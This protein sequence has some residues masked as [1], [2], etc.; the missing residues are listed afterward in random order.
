MKYADIILPIPLEQVYTYGVPLALQEKINI[1]CRVE[2]SFGKRKIYSGI[3]KKL[4]DHKPEVYEVKPIRTII[5][6]EPIVTEQ[7][8]QLWE[9]MAQYYMCTLGEVMNAAMPTHYKLVSDT[10]IELQPDADID[11]Q[12]LSDDEFMIME[13]LLINQSRNTNKNK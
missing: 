10:I 3:V 7:Q 4:H 8:L 5:D 13:A 12:Q 1:G 9:W 6:S 2:V 11:A